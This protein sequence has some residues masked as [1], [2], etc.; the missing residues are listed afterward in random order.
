MFN[1][2]ESKKVGFNKNNQKE[3]VD[4]KSNYSGL[5]KSLAKT[6]RNSVENP[7][8]ASSYEKGKSYYAY[9]PPN[10]LNKMVKSFKNLKGEAFE[11]FI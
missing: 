7:I 1:N 9:Q 8:E 11:E 3:S 6:L 4:W 5:Y 10:F 2:I